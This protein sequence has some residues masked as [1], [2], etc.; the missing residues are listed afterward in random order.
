MDYIMLVCCI[1]LVVFGLVMVFSASYYTSQSKG[2]DGTY[3]LLKQVLG[4]ALG[5]VV[6]M[7]CAFLPLRAYNN[8]A[9][10]IL[11][12]LVSMGLLIWALML[13]DVNGAKRWVEIA[14]QSVQ[15]SEIGRVAVM[16]F[17]AVWLARYQ[18]DLRSRIP[19][20]F[21]RAILPPLAVMGVI[22]VLIILGSNLSMAAST[23]LLFMVMIIAAGINWRAFGTFMGLG[24]LAVVL[25]TVLEP[26][27][28]RRMLI[29]SDP[30]SDPQK[31]GYQLVQSLYALGSGGLFGVGLGNSRQ[32]YLYLPY[33]ESDFIL[34]II[35]EEFGFVGLCVLMLVFWIFIWRGI[36]AAIKAPDRFSMLMGIGIVGLVAVQLLINVAVVTSSMP[37]TGVPLPFISAGNS[38]LIVFMALTGILLNISRYS[39]ES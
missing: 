39:Q 33:S 23:L 1:G 14:G 19:R 20:R 17:T 31:N 36:V 28:L 35:G 9:L 24:G 37:P 7:I 21:F 4:A 22:F 12:T 8:L 30:F 6:M 18:D 16:Y 13:P 3:F 38:S 11:L 26:Y 15:P 25:L 10:P 32:K 2:G 5:I 27:R 34:S 29:F